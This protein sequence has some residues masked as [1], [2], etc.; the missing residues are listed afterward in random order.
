MWSSMVFKVLSL[1]EGCDG[2]SACI[3]IFCWS[4]Q[5]VAAS[6]CRKGPACGCFEESLSPS[7]SRGLYSRVI[8]FGDAVPFVRFCVT[9][10]PTHWRVRLTAFLVLCQAP[11]LCTLPSAVGCILRSSCAE[12]CSIVRKGWYLQK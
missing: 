4:E 8:T 12:S 6:L 9:R 11:Y 7:V 3:F 5:F 2:G 1:W 10:C